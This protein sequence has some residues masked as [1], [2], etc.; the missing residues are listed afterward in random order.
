MRKV[1]IYAL[2]NPK[3]NSPFYVGKTFNL[4]RRLWEHK[5]I[6]KSNSFKNQ[7]V[8]YLLREKIYPLIKPLEECDESNWKE[9]EKFWISKIKEKHELLNSTAGGD[10]PS[11]TICTRVAKIDPLTD[12]IIEI[13][14]SAAEASEKNNLKSTSSIFESCSGRNTYSVNF[15]WRRI[16]ES[17]N[18]ITPE[19]KK[20][21]RIVKINYKDMKIVDR[22][23]HLL[24]ERLISEFGSSALSSINNVCNGKTRS[25]YGYIWRKLDNNGNIIIP[26]FK[27]KFKMINQLDERRNIIERFENAKQAGEQLGY[28]SDYILNACRTKELYN[29]FFWEFNSF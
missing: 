19:I 29:K 22:Y 27:Y 11:I 2:I 26:I 20:N 4:T 3:T 21:R 25:A 28:V 9:K 6:T 15:M 13:Y 23:I 18:I 10:E 24:D 5:Q 14:E 7:H 16:D 1:F 17:G 8:Q 12:K